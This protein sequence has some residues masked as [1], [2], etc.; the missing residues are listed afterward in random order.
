MPAHKILL[1]II[2]TLITLLVPIVLCAELRASDPTE[3]E[4]TGCGDKNAPKACGRDGG[5]L[6]NIRLHEP[7]GKVCEAKIEEITEEKSR[8]NVGCEEICV[9]RV[10]CP[11]APGGSGITTF[12][13]MKNTISTGGCNDPEC[14]ENLPTDCVYCEQPRCGDVRCIR[15]LESEDYET[16][17]CVAEW[18]I[19]QNCYRYGPRRSCGCACD[20]NNCATGASI[21]A[22]ETPLQPAPAELPVPRAAKKF[23]EFWK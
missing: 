2:V 19:K 9:P 6:C 5:P 7:C 11:W 3:Q 15:T 4:E 8:W 12:N 1:P 22:I 13:F 23:Y 21:E 10:V 17:R 16:R 14:F 20:C 18:D